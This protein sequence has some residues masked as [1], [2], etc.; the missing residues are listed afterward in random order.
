VLLCCAALAAACGDDGGQTRGMT[1]PPPE[2]DASIP[3]PESFPEFVVGET[4]GLSAGGRLGVAQA[5]IVAAS[6]IPPIV[7]ENTWTVAIAD[8]AG[9]PV[10]DAEILSACVFMP[11][12]GHYLGLTRNQI[13]ALEEPGHYELDGLFFNMGGPW[14]TQLAIS[15]PSLPDERAEA[16]VCSAGSSGNEYI[17]I[18]FCVA[19]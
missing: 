12:H 19:N 13:T 14:E 6:S 2:I 9:E 7:D 8:A 15:S 5:R 16:T 10:T 17:A 4:I 3:C 11:I 1:T 18:E